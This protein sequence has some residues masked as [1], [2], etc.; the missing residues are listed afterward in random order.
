[1]IEENT[2]TYNE[3]SNA[4]E[5]VQPLSVEEN[6]VT[7]IGELL[8]KKRESKNLTLKT[9]S[10]QTKIHIGLLQ[11]LERNELDKLPSKTYVKGFVKS[12]A[13]ILNLDQEIALGILEATYNRELK[14]GKKPSP[15][16]EIKN[17]SIRPMPSTMA[18]LETVKS[19]T[20]SSTFLLAKIAIGTIVLGVIGFNVKNFIDR[21][22]EGKTKL[23]QVLST[24][25]QKTNP[26]LKTVTTNDA[27]KMTLAV[28]ET[29]APANPIQVNIIQDKKDNNQ[30]S[31]ITIN[32]I[33]FKAVSLA[34]KQFT[35]DNSMSK[36]DLNEVFPS[37]YKFP[38][39]KGVE[40]LFINAVDGDSWITY[41]VDDK[42]I[43]KYV[44]RQG[45]TVFIHGEK[46][47][48]FLG[49]TKSVKVFY[50]N[51]LINLSSK[52][53][54]KNLILPEELKTT[55][56]TPLFVFQKDGS[57]LT[58]DEYIKSNQSA[59]STTAPP[60][61]PAIKPPATIKKL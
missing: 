59:T 42:E 23:P 47:R 9:I 4:L 7:T 16:L 43:K 35:E 39:T 19:I 57:V 58:S 11:C 13:K 10:Q 52:G 51:K 8:Q 41:K 36:E 3:T 49:N 29:P 31:E 55:Y 20:A 6:R 44:L 21:S 38:P 40:N 37:R 12:T 26:A 32:D 5:N 53:G 45:R 2:K 1:M 22:T 34:E 24:I 28:P 15:N 27:S 30:K 17:G 50:N 60:S 46:I 25:H 54:V 48:L 14:I 18:S 61:N 56:M 33:K